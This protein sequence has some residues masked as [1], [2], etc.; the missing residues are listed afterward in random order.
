MIK[1]KFRLSLLA[2]IGVFLLVSSC[3]SKDTSTKN[4]AHEEST[5]ISHDD[6]NAISKAVCVLTPTEGSNVKG[7]VT[8]TQTDAGLLIVADVEGLSEGK[9]GFHIHEFGDISKS[10]GT[11]AGGHFNPEHKDHAGPE[12]EIRHAGDFGNIIADANGNAHY[13]RVDSL[14]SFKGINNIIGRSIIIHADE[15]DLVSQPTGDAGGRVA[16]GV[17]GI[18]E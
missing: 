17:I 2:T 16:Q 11:S 10:D 6:S 12:D 7:L 13:E 18:G 5:M 8:F 4:L 1:K 9:H 14:I 3:N 15:D